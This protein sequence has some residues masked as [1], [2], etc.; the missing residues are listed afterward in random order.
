[1][2]Y[3]KRPLRYTFGNLRAFYIILDQIG[4]ATSTYGTS[5]CLSS[6]I[7]AVLISLSLPV[8]ARAITMLL[9]D[10]NLNS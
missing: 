7:T 4:T 5:Y 6:L 8:L 10:R 2:E 9:A 3:G 1:M